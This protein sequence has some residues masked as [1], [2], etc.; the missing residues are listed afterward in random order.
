MCAFPNFFG[1]I[2][3]CFS[4][5]C[6]CR[7]GG[8]DGDSDCAPY[9]VRSP[10]VFVYNMSMYLSHFV[11]AKRMFIC[12][13]PNLHAVRGLKRVYL[14]CEYMCIAFRLW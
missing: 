12:M 3:N 14:Q 5:L 1:G 10:D 2:P 7:Q 11:Y 9:P 4:F 13:T 8:G 6:A